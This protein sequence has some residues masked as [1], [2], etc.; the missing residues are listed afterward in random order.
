TEDLRKLEITLADDRPWLRAGWKQFERNPGSFAPSPS[1]KRV[2][3]EFRGEI[4]SVPEKNGE[5]RN[6]VH[7]PGRRE[8]QPAWSPDGRTQTWLAEA[9]TDYELFAR[10]VATGVERQL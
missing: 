6:L 9:G 7:T 3:V 5:P 1:A 4:F 2:L 8:R 10:D